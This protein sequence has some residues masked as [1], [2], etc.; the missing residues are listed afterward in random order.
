MSEKQSAGTAPLFYSAAEPLSAQAHGSWRLRS[1]DYRF[2]AET[3]F[4]PI[5]AGEVV[6]AAHSYP[7][8]FGKGDAHPI[9]IM[10]VERENLF[11]S[12]GRWAEDAYVPAYGRPSPFGF[13]ATV[14]PAGFVLA[15]DSDADRVVREGEEGTP[16]FED[17]KPAELTRQ[18]LAFCDA[19]QGEAAATRAFADALVAEQ[20]LVDRRADVTLPDG[21]K[22][23][24][25]G[26]QI[27]DMDKFADLPDDRVLEWHRKGWLALVQFH[28]ASLDRFPALLARRM[29]RPAVPEMSSEHDEAQ[30]ALLE[31]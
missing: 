10:G 7:I 28:A 22:L 8:V 31:E 14:N 11:V 2:A 5:V 25:E 29:A 12:D 19:F 17:G 4:V 23:G 26:F 27:V 16:L 18:A 1:G 24:L 3:P 20:L 9:A 21:R 30:A 13:I 15:I 6:Q